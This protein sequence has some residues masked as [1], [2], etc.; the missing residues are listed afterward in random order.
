MLLMVFATLFSWLMLT[1]GVA[2]AMADILL[3]VSGGNHIVILLFINIV[4]IIAGMF[5]DPVSAIYILVPLFFPVTKAIAVDPIHFGTIMC[6]NLSMAH[7]TPPVGLALYL[8]ANLAKVPFE[9]A[10]KQAI[11]F[12]FCETFVIMLV[13]YLPFLSLWLPSL[14]K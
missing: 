2:A 10:V 9:R 3:K 6:V 7:L 1:Q 4:F 8:S 13:T 14:L 5:I 11:P 12:I